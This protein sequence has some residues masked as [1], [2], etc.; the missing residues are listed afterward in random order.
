MSFNIDK[1]TKKVAF[2]AF[3]A[4]DESA[5]IKQFPFENR[6]TEAKLATFTLMKEKRPVFMEN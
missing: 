4:H 2:S 5:N 3:S 1:K 6:S